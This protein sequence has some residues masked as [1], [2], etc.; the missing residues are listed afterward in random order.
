MNATV[1]ELQSSWGLL[2]PNVQAPEPQQWALWITLYGTDAVRRSVAKLAL[3]YRKSS[4][5]FAS[6]ESLYKFADALMGRISHDASKS[7]TKQGRVAPAK[8]DK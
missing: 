3:R 6:G 2:F 7:S 1:E 8:G 4:G 5:D